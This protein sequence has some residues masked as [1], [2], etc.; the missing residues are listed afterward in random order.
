MSEVFNSKDNEPPKNLNDKRENGAGNQLGKQIEE[1]IKEKPAGL[2]PTILVGSI[3]VSLLI[4]Y[5]VARVQENA[6]RQRLID[7]WMRELNKWMKQHSGMVTNPLKEG[8]EATRSAVE[9]A[10][11]SGARL[12][13]QFYPFVK[14][15]K[16]NLFGIF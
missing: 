16:R 5:F 2:Y 3:V 13:Q 10:S 4:G 8:F 14:K 11:H 6:K 12:A 7:N 15:Q 9:E 1:K